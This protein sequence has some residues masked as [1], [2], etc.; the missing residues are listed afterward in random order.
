METVEDYLKGASVKYA[1]ETGFRIG[2]HTR[3]LHVLSDDKTTVYWTVLRR[4][5]IAEELKGGGVP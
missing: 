4:L 2:A 3:W 1:D 5:E